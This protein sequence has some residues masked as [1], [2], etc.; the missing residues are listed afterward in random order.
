MSIF[1][2]VTFPGYFGQHFAGDRLW[3][4]SLGD[5]FQNCTWHNLT[6]EALNETMQGNCKLE[7]LGVWSNYGRDN[8]MNVLMIFFVFSFIAVCICS[9][10]LVPM[11]AFIPTL[12]VGAA[13]G[14]IFGEA[15]S[16][17]LFPQQNYIIYPGIYAVVG[18]SAFCTGIIHSVSVAIIMTESVGQ[19]YYSLPIFIGVVVGYG[20]SKFLHPSLYDTVIKLKKLPYIHGT[21]YKSKKYIGIEVEQIM[22]KEIDFVSQESTL[23]DIQNLLN[24]YPKV[25]TFPICDSFENQILIGSCL[26]HASLKAP[27]QCKSEILN[28]KINLN[29]IEFDVAPFQIMK[30]VSI[31]QCYKIFTLLKLKRIYITECGR[32]EGLITERELRLGIENVEKNVLTRKKD[33]KQI[34]VA[35]NK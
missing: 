14:R 24:K 22:L 25:Q 20:V 31:L 18:A 34:H 15:V 27:N 6:L 21:C 23:N 4:A 8:P 13:L 32:M 2:I 30:N 35:I 10:L 17:Y 28:T 5:L 16:F 29:E 9:T 26:K 33:I 11:G 1:G 12:V 7:Q 19:L 3:I